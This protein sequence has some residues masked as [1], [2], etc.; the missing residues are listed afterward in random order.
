MDVVQDDIGCRLSVIIPAYNAQ[1]TI[2]E[3]LEALA[4]Q[5]WSEPWELI[6]VNNRCT[7]GTLDVVAR[8]RDR[9]PRL[10]VIDAFARQGAA[11]ALNTGVRAA[12]AHAVA[13]CDA[14]DVVGE[15]WVAAM[16]E[17]LKRHVF[18]SGALE[19]KRLNTAPLARYRRESQTS[20]IQQYVYPPFLPH[21]GAGNMGMQRALFDAIGGFDESLETLFETDF[22]WKAQLR[23]IPLTPLPHAL[24]H[25]RH[26]DRVRALLRQARKYAEN[27]VVLYKRYRPLGM[28]K[29]GKKSGLAAWKYLILGV[30]DLLHEEKRAS[31]LWELGWRTGRLYGSIRHRVWAL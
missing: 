25:V 8:F 26:R 30:G 7:D 13:F 17:A 18:V 19:G 6:V 10:R 23:G 27:D 2:G 14:D 15:G 1:D 12:K 24:V 16:G 20:G 11:Y 9:L 21:A 4:A 5:Q 31:Y 29:L 28:P 3:Q 22:C